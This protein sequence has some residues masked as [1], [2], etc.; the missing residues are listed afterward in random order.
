M[1]N[2]LDLPD[3]IAGL[4]VCTGIGG[5]D[6]A[7]A[8]WV[9]PVA[10]CE[11][12][13]DAQ[14]ALL[15][16]MQEGLLPNCPIWDDLRTL[17]GDQ[18]NG[19]KIIYGGFPCQGFSVAGLGKGLGDERSLLVLE[20]FRLCGELGPQFLFLENVPAITSRGG[21]EIVGALADM[22]YDCLWCV[23]YAWE[24]GAPFKESARWF[25]LAKANSAGWEGVRPAETSRNTIPASICQKSW[26]SWKVEPGPDSAIA[27]LPRGMGY[28]YRLYG[29]AVVPE[30]ARMAF[31][32]LMFGGCE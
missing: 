8:E 4:S 21:L 26:V 5:L 23:I 6:I 9:E 28:V 12:D 16:R 32:I 3:K 19:I 25:L 15:S 1:L 11:C 27:G 2:D 29:N 22:G 30:Q 7:L 10:Y 18:L 17:R 24:A 14:A 31:Q 13:P 20:I